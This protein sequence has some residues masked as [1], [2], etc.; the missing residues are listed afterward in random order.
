MR[1]SITAAVRG[2]E[3][4]DDEASCPR[5]M[6]AT[7]DSEGDIVNTVV[8]RPSDVVGVMANSLVSMDRTVCEE[9]VLPRTA[10]E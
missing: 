6:G 7:G 5:G 10:L 1:V 3:G 4:H 8:F 2:H 9:E